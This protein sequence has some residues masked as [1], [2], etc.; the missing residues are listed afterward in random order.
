MWPFRLFKKQDKSNLPP[1]VEKYYQSEHRERVGLAWLIAFMTLILTVAIVIGLFFGGRWT[2]RKIAGNTN[3][4]ATP[5]Q[6]VKPTSVSTS[7]PAPVPGPSGKPVSTSQSQA[8]PTNSSAPSTTTS[9]SSRRTNT[10]AH[11][12][13]SHV[14]ATTST[15]KTAG[16]LSDTGPGD[17]LVLFIAVSLVGALGHTLYLRRTIGD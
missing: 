3:K 10:P 5:A 14:T 13:A 15:N 17:T 4:P 9:T 12:T 2:Y 7:K 11:T 6:P 16:K 8:P 1:E